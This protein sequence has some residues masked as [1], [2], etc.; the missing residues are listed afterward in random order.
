VPG[1]DQAQRGVGFGAVVFG[2]QVEVERG[3]SSC[4][5]KA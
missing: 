5:K 3:E 1:I 4:M 2:G